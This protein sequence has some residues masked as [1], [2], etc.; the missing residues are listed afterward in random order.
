MPGRPVPFYQRAGD[1]QLAG[2]GGVDPGEVDG[3]VGDDGDAVEG[4]LLGG[5]DGAALGGPAGFAVGPLDEV[6]GDRFDPFRFD[7]GDDAAPQPR[8]FDELGSDDPVRWLAGESGAG[9][10]REPGAPGAQVLR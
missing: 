3:A 7:A 5:D 1:E 4:D 6:G 8:G 2:H 9:E 10:D